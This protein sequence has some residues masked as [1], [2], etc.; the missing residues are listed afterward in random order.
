MKVMRNIKL[1]M[2]IDAT[3]LAIKIKPYVITIR[4]YCP[5]PKPVLFN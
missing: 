3:I 2:K 1:N 5:T 4:W